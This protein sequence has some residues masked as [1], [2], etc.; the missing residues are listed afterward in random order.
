MGSSSALEA[1]HDKYKYTFSL[2]YFQINDFH[3]NC[4]QASDN[5]QAANQT[6]EWLGQ[7]STAT[8]A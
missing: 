6:A 3:Y 1:L 5:W 8:P 4:K 7:H 2:L